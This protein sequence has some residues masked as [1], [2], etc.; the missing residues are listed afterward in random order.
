[1]DVDVLEGA[2]HKDGLEPPAHGLDLGQLGHPSSLAVPVPD[3][4]C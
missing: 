2:S 4:A 1:V 3:E